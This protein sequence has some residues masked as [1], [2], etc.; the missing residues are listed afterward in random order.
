[1][2]YTEMSAPPCGAE[3]PPFWELELPGLLTELL[4]W[5][6]EPPLLP[7][8]A[9]DRAMA[10]AMAKAKIFFIVKTPFQ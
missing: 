2:V 5:E 8:A 4:F 1:M 6:L 10:A 7:Q 9:I 3:E